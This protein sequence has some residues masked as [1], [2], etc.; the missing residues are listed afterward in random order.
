LAIRGQ[1]GAKIVTTRKPSAADS[2]VPVVPGSTKRLRTIICMTRPEIAIEAPA[3][4]S[5]TVRGMRLMR[6]TSPGRPSQPPDSKDASETS[7]T[8][9]KR[10]TIARAI[11]MII[12]AIS[13][14]TEK[15]GL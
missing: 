10:L 2:L 12:P 15:S 14:G 13:A 4:T 7:L 1:P 8:P 6:R 11:V 3:R 5:A 9:T